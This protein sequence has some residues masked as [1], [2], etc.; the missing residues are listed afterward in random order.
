MNTVSKL[1]R[2]L[3]ILDVGQGSCAVVVGDAEVIVVDV[4]R[5]SALLEFL[6]QQC[7]RRIRTVYLSHADEDHI[8]ALV[9]LLASGTVT[10]D[11]VVL[12]SDA[13]KETE[14]WRDLTYELASKYMADTLELDIGLFP[15]KSE[16]LGDIEI[17]VMAPSPALVLKG[18]GSKN[19]SG[20]RITSNSISAVIR[21]SVS[22]KHVAILPADIDGIGLD[23]LLM[24]NMDLKAPILVYPHH[25]GRPGAADIRSFTER[26]LEAVE[27]ITV[28]FSFGRGSYGAPNPEIVSVLREI[29]PDTRIVCTQ[30]SEHCSNTVP[31]GSMSHLSS[32]FALGHADHRCCGGTIVVPLDNA[33]DLKPGR[34]DHI[35]FIRS[36]VE[37]PLCLNNLASVQ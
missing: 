37:T 15:G 31:S 23:D 33:R 2:H 3:Y 30:L 7:I 12:N 14:S 21:I 22:G 24:R 32:A 4:G 19:G 6:D 27:P 20:R 17:Q 16:D 11:R 29:M 8:G 35:A 36:N 26:L 10:I 1:R 28:V 5:R 13:S 34:D 9:G 25:G 18:V